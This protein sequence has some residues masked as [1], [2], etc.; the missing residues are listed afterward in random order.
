MEDSDMALSEEHVAELCKKEIWAV[1]SMIRP[2]TLRIATSFD[3]M[4]DAV[5]VRLVP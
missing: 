4:M 3:N 2:D 5:K 1:K